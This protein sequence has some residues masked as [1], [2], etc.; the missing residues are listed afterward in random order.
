M[1]SRKG[2]TAPVVYRSSH[3]AGRLF[4]AWRFVIGSVAIDLGASIA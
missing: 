4:R 1:G 3:S 2:S